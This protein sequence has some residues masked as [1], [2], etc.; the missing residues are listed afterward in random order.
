M[1]LHH[2]SPRL[3]RAA[4]AVAACAS[5]LMTGPAASDGGAV[6]TPTEKAQF[7]ARVALPSPGE[8]FSALDRMGE[9]DW[10]N[11]GGFNTRY[12]YTDDVARALNLGVRAAD[13]FLA[14]QAQDKERLGEMV[15]VIMTLA[16]ELM[17][18]EALLVEG[19]RLE[20]MAEREEWDALR[21]ELDGL[22]RAVLSEMERLG[23]DDLA[24]LVSAGGWLAGLR[25]AST[26]LS[27]NYDPQASS[28]LYQPALTRHFKLK[29]DALRPA[30]TSHPTVTALRASLDE[31]EPLIDV[32]FGAPVP[33]ENIQ[34]LRTLSETLVRSIEETSGGA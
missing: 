8:I 16:D 21:R 18:E 5:L 1:L 14:I 26:V 27:R 11:A 32:G 4:L 22:R 13:G 6:P 25:A 34:R 29:L 15:T 24:T 9:A 30:L 20:A 17:V 12:D 2:T 7:A 31:I 33:P 3:R 10:R 28:L 19:R 23:D